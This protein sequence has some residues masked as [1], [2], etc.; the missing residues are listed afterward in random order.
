MG[1]M[2]AGAGAVD[3]GGVVMVVVGVVVAAAVVCDGGQNAW[4]TNRSFSSPRS[5][6]VGSGGGGTWMDVLEHESAGVDR[7]ASL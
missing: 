4:S 5:S 2:V 1:V 3:A 6:A 7:F